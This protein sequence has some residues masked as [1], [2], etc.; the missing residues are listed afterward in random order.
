MELDINVV[1]AALVSA[2]GWNVLAGY[3]GVPS[4][5]THAII[6]G[7][8]GAVLLSIGWEAVVWYKIIEVLLVLI[9][10]PI[11]GIVLGFLLT[12][13]AHKMFGS[14]SPKSVRRSFLRSQIISS[15]AL[16]LSHGTNDAQK[17]MGVI[18]LALIILY[19]QD[20]EAVRFFYDGGG[21]SYI[22]LWV[23]ISCASAISLGVLTGGFRI[24]KTLGGGIYKIRS[25]HGFSA[26]ASSAV[27][28]Y[29]SALLGFPVSTTQVVSSSIV[30]AGTAERANAVRWGVVG[31]ILTTWLITVP[32]T[33]VIGGVVYF[34][35]DIICEYL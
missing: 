16:S 1:W 23:K 26:Q 30:G 7:L 25:V 24:M 4:S 27:I 12:R 13:L 34:I 14:F 2:F 15:A 31:N 32:S 20:P 33:V 18:T 6:G 35:I 19:N 29:L 22:P 17:T 3:R 8:M 5:S 10:S 9:F 28:I 11:L 21:G